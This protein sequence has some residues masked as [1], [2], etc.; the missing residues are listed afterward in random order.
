MLGLFLYRELLAESM[1]LS[2]FALLDES[3]EDLLIL[4]KLRTLLESKSP[5]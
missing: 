3:L 5:V 1:R 2:V 4:E